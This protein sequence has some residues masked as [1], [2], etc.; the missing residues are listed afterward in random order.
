MGV[1]GSQTSRYH[2]MRNGH[3]ERL[4]RTLHTTLSHYVD[5]AHTDWDLRVSFFLIA[6]H[7]MTHSTRCYSSYYL[8]H[9]R[10]IIT[11]AT[12]NLKAKV[13]RPTQPLDQQLKNLKTCWKMAYKTVA[14]ANK[15]AHRANKSPYDREVRTRTFK[16]GD[17]VYLYN[18]AVKPGLSKK[19]HFLWSG[20]FQVTAKLSYLN[21]ELLHNQGRKFVVHVNRMKLPRRRETRTEAGTQT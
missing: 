2:P 7:S 11:P 10:E 5:Q 13:P 14:A 6:Y 12:E 19:F 15:E 3:A 17:Y 8:L 21:Y 4:H 9:G 18:P 1:C 16:E 20:P